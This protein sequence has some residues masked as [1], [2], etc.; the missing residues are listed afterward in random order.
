MKFA[1]EITIVC[2]SIKRGCEFRALF[3]DQTT[4]Q[5]YGGSGAT[6]LDALAWCLDEYVGRVKHGM[7]IAAARNAGLT[8]GERF[9]G[10]RVQLSGLEVRELR[11]SSVSTRTEVEGPQL[12]P[13]VT[14]SAT[15]F[16]AQIPRPATPK[17]VTDM[18]PKAS[19]AA[20]RRS[21]AKKKQGASK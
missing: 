13:K 6:A 3:Y 7:P 15:C 14:T 21:S 18:P 9:G 4:E 16:D 8:P 11:S 12:A 17:L 2:E 19:S 10:A 20:A 1:A 5:F